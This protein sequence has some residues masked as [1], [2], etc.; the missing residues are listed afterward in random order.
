MCGVV[1][2]SAVEYLEKVHGVEMDLKIDNNY[3]L[4]SYKKG[5]DYT[6]WKTIPDEDPAKETEEQVVN[7][8]QNPLVFPMEVNVAIAAQVTAYG[9]VLIRSLINKIDKHGGLVAYSATDS[10]YTN[11]KL[12][13]IPEFSKL[14]GTEMGQFKQERSFKQGYFARTGL[15]GLDGC[16]G[17]R[18]T[19][20]KHTS[21]NR[22]DITFQD[23]KELALYG[24]VL[25]RIKAQ[26]SQAI[27]T[28]KL[29]VRG[30]FS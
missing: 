10:V 13:E 25:K 5:A 6:M 9:R 11:L 4:V 7:S 18:E 20:I 22:P 8:N 17:K 16:S 14:V 23:V 30:A 19:I 3:H 29:G 12:E 26:W 2:A 15:Y 27:V 21:Y 24:T 1:E 28:D